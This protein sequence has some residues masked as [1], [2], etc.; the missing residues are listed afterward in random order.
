MQ[1]SF[2]SDYSEAEVDELF[3]IAPEYSGEATLCE[4]VPNVKDEVSLQIPEHELK[5]SLS[6]VAATEKKTCTTSWATQA[7][8][9]ADFA[10]EQKGYK[11]KFSVR[12]LY[13]CMT[14][15]Y[16]GESDDGCNGFTNNEI[17]AFIEYHGLMMEKDAQDLD[18]L[19]SSDNEK[20]NIKFAVQRLTCSNK[21]TLMDAL[22][23]N[24]AM[25]V[26]LALDDNR[27]RHIRD[28]SAE[29]DAPYTGASDQPSTWAITT[30]YKLDGEEGTWSLQSDFA[31]DETVKFKL[32]IRNNDTN[33]NY[34]GIAAFA[35]YLEPLAPTA[36]PTEVPTD[37]PQPPTEVPAEPTT[38]AP[39]PPTEVPPEP[40]TEAPIEPTTEAPAEPTTEAP[41]EPTTEAPIEPTTEPP[42]EPTTEPPAEPTTEPPVEPTTEPPAEPTTLPPTTLPPRQVADCP[43]RGM[44]PCKEV[45]TAIDDPETVT[46]LELCRCTGAIDFSMF[47]NLRTLR[48]SFM[49]D[50]GDFYLENMKELTNVIIGEMGET[51]VGGKCD[52][53]STVVIS[54]NPKLTDMIIE[55]DAFQKICIMEIED[56][57]ELVNLG[58]GAK[59]DDAND[60]YSYTAFTGAFSS[61]TDAVI[62]NMPKLENIQLGGSVMYTF[63]N[64]RIENLPILKTF[65]LFAS[66]MQGNDAGASM[67]MRSKRIVEV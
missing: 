36:E 29:E 53:N 14:A 11:E 37:A 15:E 64:L 45:V 31:L 23:Q 62:A 3:T 35:Y 54:H 26:L 39:Q 16:G 24:H 9:A 1:L 58:I 12:Y 56:N 42:A 63:E 6:A 8:R 65:H 50:F 57:E 55:V 38:V 30:G 2:L 61:T 25:V 52:A 34:A 48:I 41:A 27:A 22:S 46:D 47:P 67:V 66:A 49:R 43:N 28:I 4:E 32:P 19:C 18:D 20:N 7:I 21:Y 40:T 33:A 13:Q 44:R 17:Y 10:Y 5:D 59:Y 51:T 60:S